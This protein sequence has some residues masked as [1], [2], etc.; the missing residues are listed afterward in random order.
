MSNRE[1]RLPG[2]DAPEPAEDGVPGTTT[3]RSSI[4][5]ASAFLAS[6]TLVSRLLGFL[7][8]A[9][10]T[11]ALGQIG[12]P[13]DS[14]A[15]ANQLPTTIY[16]LVAGG[17]LSAVIV[18]QI[19]KA[20]LHDDGGARFI[21]RL[22]T[23]GLAIFLPLT[24]LAT[25]G[26]PV[27]T[28]IYT[29]ADAPPELVA[30]TTAFAFW[31]LPQIFFYGVYSL[32]GETLNARGVFGPFTWAPVLNNIVS[33]SGI[34]T[35]IAVFGGG[36]RPV[37]EWTPLMI[38]VVGGTATLGIVTQAF[39][40]LLFWRRAGLRYRPDFRWRGV[41]LGETGRAAGWVFGMFLVS[42]VGGIVEVR[43]AGEVSGDASV[44]T[45]QKGWLM[46]MLPHSVATVSIVTAYFTR[47]STH[48]RDGD[49]P[50]VRRDLTAALR[51]VL[52][53]MVFSAFGLA[54][55][56]APFSVFFSTNYAETQ[57]LATVYIAY[58]SGLVSFTIFFVLL[59]VFYALND[60]RSAFL[61]QIAQTSF[62]VIACLV[63]GAFVAP[64]W[65]AASL[66][67][68]LAVA[69]T[70]QA[71]LS[72]VVLRKRLGGIGM[73]EVL[74]QALWFVAAA[75]PAAAAGIGVLWMLGGVG[76]GSFPV[77]GPLQA[78]ASMLITGAT[79]VIVYILVLAVTRNPELRSLAAPVTRRLRRRS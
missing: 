14:F 68:S 38:A 15:I 51:N 24:V 60:T 79:M 16:S 3:T 33:I 18:P 19:V 9:V 67:L 65:T 59:R 46:F 37:E 8:A 22:V 39:G 7:N 54:V 29:D 73:R 45:M 49:R 2:P 76:E 63:V 41:G 57:A 1:E 34:A 66:A 43:T 20:G 6:G 40:L 75:V 23:L 17:L 4:G 62:Y 26:A 58:L 35:F 50:A 72:A 71:V 48:M 30:M 74:G 52:I 56:A 70:I 78:A 25:L 5:R 13:A 53:I 10:L 28:W 27:L 32:V 31:C 44:A 21:N 77:S 69:N 64:E 42:M 55:L 12:V 47:M 11:Q 36:Q 61:I